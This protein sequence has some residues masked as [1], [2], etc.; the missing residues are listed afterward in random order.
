V[1][2]ASRRGTTYKKCDRFGPELV[3]FSKC[4]LENGEPEP[5][6]M[7]GLADVRV[8]HALLESQEKDKPVRISPPKDLAQPL[9]E[10]EIRKPPGEGPSLVKATAPS[11]QS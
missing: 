5:G 9:E 1:R 3:Y 4:I 6:G 7:E 10:Q 2:A 11:Q 8:I